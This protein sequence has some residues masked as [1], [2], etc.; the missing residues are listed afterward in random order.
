MQIH[1]RP[2]QLHHQRCTSCEAICVYFLKH[3]S[4]DLTSYASHSLRLNA[5]PHQKAQVQNEHS[6]ATT[7]MTKAAPTAHTPPTSLTQATA[8]PAGPSSA[9]TSTA[10]SDQSWGWDCQWRQCARWR[11]W[12]VAVMSQEDGVRRK[13]KGR[14]GGGEVE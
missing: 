9:T 11:S 13:A 4:P 7:P 1:V 10:P 5:S 14:K 2:Q 8:T 6:A 3:W 12:A